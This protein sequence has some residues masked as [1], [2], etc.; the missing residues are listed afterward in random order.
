L[1]M[2]LPST[3]SFWSPWFICIVIFSVKTVKNPN[4]LNFRIKSMICLTYIRIWI[5]Y[6]CNLCDIQ[7]CAQPNTPFCFVVWSGNIS[8]HRHLIMNI[9]SFDKPMHWFFFAVKELYY[10]YCA[11]LSWCRLH[12]CMLTV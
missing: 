5:M 12:Y 9:S 10:F 6:V 8:Y 7:N 3:N 2:A 11:K 1:K 4:F